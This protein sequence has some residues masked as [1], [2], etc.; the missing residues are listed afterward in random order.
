[1]KARLRII[2]LL[3]I[4]L[5]IGLSSSAFS[6][7]YEKIQIKKSEKIPYISIIDSSILLLLDSMLAVEKECSYYHDSICFTI[8]ICNYDWD[9][10]Q[11]C[12]LKDSMIVVI[13]SVPHKPY[14]FLNDNIGHFTLYGHLCFVSGYLLPE[15]FALTDSSSII[16]STETQFKRTGP[17]S[18]GQIPIIQIEDDSKTVWEYQ[19]NKNGLMRVNRS[20]CKN[21]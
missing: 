4:V 5:S 6:Q 10:G 11:E 8:D 18:P 12:R 17:Y 3:I 13:H 9:F 19:Y 7:S 21:Y 2:E 15:L 1:M 20:N 16:T 14:I